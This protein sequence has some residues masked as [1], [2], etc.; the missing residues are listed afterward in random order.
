M[1]VDPTTVRLVLLEAQRA[2]QTGWCQ[3]SP[4]QRAS[5]A[6]VHVESR[7]AC[8]WSPVGALQ[9]ATRRRGLAWEG[10]VARAAL[11]LVR[12]ALDELY[13]GATEADRKTVSQFAICNL[14][15]DWNDRDDRTQA[16]ALEVLDVALQKSMR[17]EEAA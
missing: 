2:L 9:L 15:A 5:G 16:H 7:Y 17:E 11:R 14:I 13:A 6:F 3:R 10:P 4:A 8:R 12:D 1:S